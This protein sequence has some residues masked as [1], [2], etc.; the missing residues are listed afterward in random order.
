[1]RKKN[2]SLSHRS[3]TGTVPKEAFK[4]LWITPGWPLMTSEASTYHS[5]RTEKH[6]CTW[7]TCMKDVQV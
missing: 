6:E 5:G 2:V 3:R 1:M 4:F 7:K